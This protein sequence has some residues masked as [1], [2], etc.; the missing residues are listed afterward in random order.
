MKCTCTP[1]SI[2]VCHYCA[3]QDR[4]YQLKIKYQRGYVNMDGVIPMLIIFGVI[5][6]VII[7]KVVP[8]LWLLVKPFIH[9]VTA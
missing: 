3:A 1:G 2:K 6:G 8:W 7:C 5:V 9:A 4:E